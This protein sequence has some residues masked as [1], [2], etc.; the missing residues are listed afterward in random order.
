MPKRQQAQPSVGQ[1][2]SDIVRQRLSAAWATREAEAREY[3]A[4]ILACV[5][6]RIRTVCSPFTSTLVGSAPSEAAGAPLST[7]LE[8][9][10]DENMMV[11]NKSL[12]TS[13]DK[14]AV[15]REKPYKCDFEGCTYVCKHSHHLVTHKRTHSGEKPFKCDFEGCGHAFAQSAHLVAHK[16]THSGEKPYTCDFEG[17]NYK[18][19][20]S[21]HLVTHKRIH[22][23]E[24]P[25]QCDFE[26]CDYK[27]TTSTHLT[28]HKRT[29]S[30]EKPFKCDFEGCNYACADRGN[31]T[32][33]QCH[34]SG[35]K[36]HKCDVEGCSYA[37]AYL[38]SL[39]VHKRT[40][41]GERPYK[42]D[43][44]GCVF[45]CTSSGTL[46]THKRIH[47][48]EKPHK[49]DFESCDYAGTRSS[50]LIT[51]KRSMHT[52][53]G[54]K[55]QLKQQMRVANLLKEAGYTVDE[56]CTIQYGGCV[57]DPDRHRARLDIYIV[58]ITSCILIVEVDEEAHASYLVSCELTRMLQ[59]HEA[60]LSRGYTVP[61][62][63][64]RYNPN[65]CITKDGVCIKMT[66][67]EREVVL[68]EFLG[69]VRDGQQVFQEP[70]NLVY[71]CYPTTYGL[72]TVCEDTDF[73]E[74]MIGTIRFCV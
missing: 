37:S 61:V 13:G 7:R 68:L 24:K 28:V 50:H 6:E 44:E 48:G 47:S 1:Q 31:L 57:P 34:H 42:C 2:R 14:G 70:L 27:C 62:V 19:A 53:E 20:R 3:E 38:C 41:S 74:G 55:R 54:A 45:S 21:H 30:G 59:V 36:P 8:N 71:L 67:E 46:I 10:A 29:H 22:S 5:Q 11:C 69:R 35:E 72:P 40:H 43:F 60:I 51:H 58:T 32:K 64:V 39:V 4:D 49:C 16:R 23:G 63:F 15:N 56:E 26:G 12:P 33:H 73:D 9:E 65:G 17:C 18:C 52:K 66:R 25:F